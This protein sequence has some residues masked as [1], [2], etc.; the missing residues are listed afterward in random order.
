[1]ALGRTAIGLLAGYVV[2]LAIIFLRPPTPPAGNYCERGGDRG[3]YEHNCLAISGTKPDMDRDTIGK[4]EWR[5][6]PPHAPERNDLAMR[7]GGKAERGV[8]YDLFLPDGT[9]PVGFMD[10]DGGWVILSFK[11]DPSKKYWMKTDQPT[12][13]SWAE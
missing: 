7:R 11:E 13:S 1:V 10:H 5:T 8:R 4:V 6:W 12:W 2:V 9:Q 3:T